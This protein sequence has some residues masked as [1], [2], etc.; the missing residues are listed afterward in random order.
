MRGKLG[1]RCFGGSSGT[2]CPPTQ[3]LLLTLPSGN[4]TSSQHS[5]GC[6]LCE[7]RKPRWMKPGDCSSRP[8]CHIGGRWKGAAGQEK[9]TPTSPR[10]VLTTGCLP[11]GKHFRVWKRRLERRGAAMA[12]RQ[13]PAASGAALPRQGRKEAGNPW[14]PPRLLT[15]G[16]ARARMRG[17]RDL[18]LALVTSGP[19]RWFRRRAP[20]GDETRREKRRGEA[21]PVQVR[22][23]GSGAAGALWGRDGAAWG[24]L[25]AGPAAGCWEGEVSPEGRLPGGAG[26]GRGGRGRPPPAPLRPAVFPRGLLPAL[27]AAAAAG[28]RPSAGSGRRSGRPGQPWGRPL[29]VEARRRARGWTP[30]ASSSPRGERGAEGLTPRAG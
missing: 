16:R 22:E 25:G 17:S 12:P 13:E 20:C 26:L 4:S 10:V 11:W 2:L 7:K 15:A 30:A 8:P 1:S 24:G 19:G 14:P 21:A 27:P 23:G 6:L 28:P 9:M 29:P 5:S 18:L 3:Q